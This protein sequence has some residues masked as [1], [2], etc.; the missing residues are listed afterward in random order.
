MATYIEFCIILFLFMIT[1]SRA[2]RGCLGRARER[3]RPIFSP[4]QGWSEGDRFIC[5]VL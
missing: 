2:A 4:D 5:S 1:K 3:C